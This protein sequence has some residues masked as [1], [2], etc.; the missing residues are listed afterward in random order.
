MT[1]RILLLSVSAGAGHVRAADALE[2][3]ISALA[4]QGGQVEALH[5]DVMDFVPSSFRRIYAD[6]YLGLITRYPRLWG[7]LYRITDDARPDAVV[8]R[9]RR[10]IE[11]LNTRRL[12][13]AIADF[14]PDAIVCTHFLPAEMLAR[15]IRK[16]RVSAPVYLQVT[17]FD[18][19][20]MWLVPGMSGYFAGSPEI[21]HRMH[22]VGLPAERVHTTGIPVM[23]AFAERHDRSVLAH[24]FGM[25]PT[26]P[27][28]LVMGG[29]AGVG[30]L[31]ELADTLLSAGGDFQLVVLAGRNEDMLGRLRRLAAGKHA[32]RLFPQGYTRHV[33]QLMACCDLAITKPGG[34]TTSECLAMG[35]P[36]IVNAPIPG[37]EERNADYLLE[38]GAAWKAIDAV[39]LAWRIQALRAD[40]AHLAAMAARARAIGRP[41]A[42]RDV[43]DIVLAQLGHR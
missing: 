35:L 7:M 41:H 32:G 22:A 20:R 36:M 25:D 24:R 6:F 27:A 16:G 19:H 13:A 38:Q 9:M 40:P 2:A 8:Q 11:R 37:Q 21:A 43:V 33:E 17:D 10:T 12:R 42:A 26:R 5:L 34:L 23:P 1:R 18:L 14:A 30:A 29:G 3:T 28:Y 39:A 31:D 4:A 15:Q